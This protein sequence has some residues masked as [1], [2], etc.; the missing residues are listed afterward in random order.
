MDLVDAVHGN[1]QSK[2]KPLHTVIGPMLAIPSQRPYRSDIP[3]LVFSL[4]VNEPGCK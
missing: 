2:A 3:S 4:A 1:T